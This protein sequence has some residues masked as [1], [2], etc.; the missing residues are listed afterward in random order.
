MNFQ[1]FLSVLRLRANLAFYTLLGTIFLVMAVSLLLPRQ[2]TASTAVVIDAKSPDPVAGMVLPGVMQPGY[3][4]TQVDIVNSDRVARHAV[5]LLRLEQQPDTVARWTKATGGRGEIVPWIAGRLQKRLYVKPSRDSNV[6]N[7]SFTDR[8][9]AF[10][11]AAANAFAQ[12]YIDVSLELRVEPARQHAGWFETQREQARDRL[13]A[14]QQALAGFQKM[15]GIV[16]SPEQVDAETARLNELSAQLTAIQIQIQDSHSKNRVAGNAETLLEVMQ[17]PVIQQLKSDLARAEVKLHETRSRLGERHPET[18]RSV[19]EVA[20]G[21]ARLAAETRTIA[22][23]LVTSHAVG[24]QKEKELLAAIEAQKTRVLDLNKDLNAVALL[25][26]DVDSA[27]KS[28]DE[29]GQRLASSRLDSASTQTNASVLN[30]ASE[31]PNPSKP[32]LL[33][34]FITSIFLGTFLA[35]GLVLALEF[36]RRRV[37]SADDIAVLAGLPLLATIGSN[38]PRLT[39]RESMLAVL[40]IPR[41]AGLPQRALPLL[42]DRRDT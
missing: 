32:N 35:A 17:S 25:R 12:A 6:I 18:Q 10:S 22:G 41:L 9:P 34:N 36:L 33:L 29:I 27:Q 2:Y 1:L 39:A 7:I 28:L 19:A 20:S 42:G 37:H 8:D 21:K 24:K 26:R 38:A 3:M 40:A 23:S 30:P 31:P 13:A 16:V 11:A 5:G 15:H 4:S 14:A